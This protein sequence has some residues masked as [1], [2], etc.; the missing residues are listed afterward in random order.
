[1]TVR[2]ERRFARLLTTLGGLVLAQILTAVAMFVTARRVGPTNFGSFAGLYGLSLG[3]GAALDFGSSA[4]QIREL[5]AGN[6]A[7]RFRVWLVRRTLLQ[8]PVAAVFAA[9]AWPW[10][11]KDVGGWCVVALAAHGLTFTYAQGAL[12]PV[13]AADASRA[14]WLVAIGNLLAVAVALAS[15]SSYVVPAVAAAFAASWLLT[16]GLA[17]RW[18]PAR[19]KASARDR[20]NPWRGAGGFGLQTVA[21]SLQ[22]LDVAVIRAVAGPLAAGELGAVARWAQPIVVLGSTTALYLLPEMAAASSDEDASRKLRDVVPLVL[23]GVIAAGAI[24]LG[25]PTI[26]DALLGEQ[27]AGSVNLLRL[28]TLAMVPVLVTMPLATLLQ[29]RGR[30]R[31]AATASVS[32]VI[33]ALALQIILARWIGAAAAPVSALCCQVVT[34]AV[35]VVAVRRMLGSD[36][37]ALTLPRSRE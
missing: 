24:I 5:A 6:R 20:D 36:A 37:A 31:V 15:P 1:M 23:L 26:V 14:T 30:E 9:V 34:L 27:F 28:L 7:S 29:A 18:W 32:A 25:A 16:S 8:L 33:G 13:R 2:A 19:S 3:V 17:A 12:A 10:F 35:L 11:A 21:A 22:T 4:L